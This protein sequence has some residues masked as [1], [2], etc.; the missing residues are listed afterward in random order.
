MP[1]KVLFEDAWLLVVEKPSG[2]LAVPGRGSDK[3]DCLSERA[4]QA[5]PGALIVH[6][7]DRDTSGLMLMARH[8]EAQR[9]LNRAFADRQV[10]K[11]YAALVQ[12][13]VAEESG[14]IDLP[15]RKDFDRPPRHMVDRALGRPAVTEYRVVH[16]HAD[17]TRLDVYP[18]TGRSHQIRIHLAELGHAI[19]GDPLYGCAAGPPTWG[20]L[21]LH[22]Q[23][24]S[25]QHPHTARPLAFHSE[26][27][28]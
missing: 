23:G 18:H 17:R 26:C 1:P 5:Y 21:M 14:R 9:R 12:G 24:L 25:L 15:L 28:F 27:P 13:S 20:R 8:A 10:E 2:L 19:L 7:L 11:S 22:A 3:Q 16:R 6:R 4:R